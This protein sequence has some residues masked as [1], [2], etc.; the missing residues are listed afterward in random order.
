MGGARLQACIAAV[1]SWIA[2]LAPEVM[3]PS[4]QRLKPAHF[5]NLN[6]T[7]EPGLFTSLR[8]GSKW[9]ARL[10]KAR[11]TCRRKL[12]RRV[13][14]SVAAET[15]SS[16]GRKASVGSTLRPGR[17]QRAYFSEATRIASAAGHRLE[18]VLPERLKRP[19]AGA[20][21]HHAAYRAGDQR[22][23][24]EQAYPQG[25][26]LRLA[27][28]RGQAVPKQRHQIVGAGVQQQTKGVGQKTLAAQTVGGKAVL[29]FGNAVFTLSPVLI[30]VED[31]RGG[32]RTVGD[33]VTQAA[34]AGAV[35]GFAADAAR[36]L[37]P[38]LAAMP[39]A[40]VQTLPLG[41]AQV[42]A[43]GFF[44]QRLAAPLKGR[45]AADA[46]AV[47]DSP[48]LAKLVQVG[49]GKAG[50]AHQADGHARKLTPQPAHQAPQYRHAT[51]RAAHFAAAQ[52][53]RQQVSGVPLED[54]QGMIDATIIS[55]VVEAE[56]LLAIGG[57]GGGVDIQHDLAGGGHAGAAQL[58]KAATQATI[59]GHPI[60]HGEAVFPA[61]EGGL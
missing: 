44:R 42:A 43:V 33:H 15:R 14:I 23:Q 16:R 46:E 10:G 9:R 13:K 54:E 48:G 4:P 21:H 40:A 56:L 29:Q 52:M 41:V 55:A 26:D 37:S 60:A 47:L 59:H 11:R 32:A 28:R 7:A 31:L 19:A 38:A 22:S 3:F 17:R 8:R 53:R 35:F 20:M 24:F 49:N 18:G 61:A 12:P 30:E 5:P 25:L 50:I 58:R 1:S 27:Q 39:E 2:L 34:A 45:I 6:C 36:A 57:I 51:A